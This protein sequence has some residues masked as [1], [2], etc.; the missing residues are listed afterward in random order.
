MPWLVP[1]V[2]ALV[3]L[4]ALGGVGGWFAATAR[5][6]FVAGIDRFLPRG[7]RPSCT[8]AG[9]TPY[10]ALLVQAA[11][12][13]LFVFLGQAG[14]SVRGAYD[15]LVSMGIIAYFIPFLFMF[16]AM[17]KL[18]R[19]P[20]GP[21][22]DAR[23]GRRR[24]AI[25]LAAL[26]LRR[27]RRRR[28]S[29]RACP[30][31][32]SRT[33]R[34]RWSRWSARRSRSSQSAP[35]IYLGPWAKHGRSMDSICCRVPPPSLR[36]HDARGLLPHGQRHGGALQP[37]PRRRRAAAV[38]G[39]SGAADRRH[40]SRQVLLRG[41]STPRAAKVV[42]SRG[43]SSIYGEWETTGEAKSMN[44]TFS[45][46]LRFPGVDKPVRDRREEARR[47]ERVSRRLDVHGRS[48]R[49]VHRATAP[50]ADAGAADQAARARRS[51][52][53]SSIC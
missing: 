26:G 46:S 17:I 49:Q 16:A 6:P 48:G 25:A 1:I 29:W 23:A 10:V 4:N 42:Y 30:P 19:E 28:S 35:M 14:T 24:V 38:A 34:W 44:R 39:Q 47:E 21:E 36:R 5:L 40:Q 27:H 50:Q 7:V 43:F 20:A 9:S 8:R 41:R 31:T 45:E 13:G 12:A 32:T 33:R 51:R 18:Q 22:R 2:A 53:R 15:A 3:T 37:R 11:I 52:R